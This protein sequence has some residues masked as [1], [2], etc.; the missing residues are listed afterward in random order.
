MVYPGSKNG[1]GVYQAIINQIPPHE[2]YIEPFLGSGAVYRR[3]RPAR[4]QLG[5]DLDLQTL[6]EF[7]EAS[8]ARLYQGPERVHPWRTWRREVR[9]CFLACAL[10]FLR[11]FVWRGDEFVYVDPPYLKT[12]RRSERPIYRH[13]FMEHSQHVELLDLLCQL[14]CKIALSGY[15]SGL[16]AERLTGWRLVQFTAQT[17]R[18]PATESLWCNYPEPTELHDYRFLGG[19][20]SERQAIK[21][22]TARWVSKLSSMSA[23]ERQVMMAALEQVR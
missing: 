7:E 10:Q 14:P 17:H 3:I 11:E 12:V 18:G 20:K 5:V 23:L 8:G 6:R 21:R 2:V 4:V 15:D 19:N 22:K 1:E 13:E 16:Y 9:M